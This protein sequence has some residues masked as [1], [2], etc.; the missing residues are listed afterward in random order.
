MGFFQEGSASLPAETA[1]KNSCKVK[2]A[3]SKKQSGTCIPKETHEKEK[4]WGGEAWRH[5]DLTAWRCHFLGLQ[6]DRS[7]PTLLAPDFWRPRNLLLPHQIRT[8]KWW[9]W[10]DSLGKKR[11]RDTSSVGVVDSI[12]GWHFQQV[13]NSDWLKWNLWFKRGFWYSFP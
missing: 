2:L 13:G 11:I 9:S 4:T 1:L 10:W 6:A 7:T 5:P 3:I 12:N 8:L